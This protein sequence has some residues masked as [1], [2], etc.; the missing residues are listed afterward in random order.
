MI[1]RRKAAAGPFFGGQTFFAT[2]AKGVEEVLA[3]E[4]IGLGL[5]GVTVE[6]GG[7][8]FTGDLGACYRANLWL[9]TA[10][11]ILVPLAE[12]PCDSPQ[13]LYDGVR[14]LPWDRY[15]TP[16]TT[17][18]V[19]CV[20]RDSAL[21]HSGFVALKT[22]DAIVDTLRDRFGRRP[23][24]NPKD[25]D[26]LVNV[27]L[28]RNRCT[29]S[30]DSSG[31]GLDRRGYRTEAGEA[32]LRE[33]LAAALVFLTGWDGTVPL[34]DPLC[35]SGTIL[36]EAALMAMNRAPGLVRE[37]FGFQRW[38][39]FDAPRWRRLLDEARQ[40]ERTT[41]AAPL[42]GYDRLE[43]VLV[44]ARNNSRR[45]GVER[46]I[47]FTEGD[48]RDLVPPP[49]P[50]VLL[51]NPPYGKRLGDEEQLKPFYGQI[52]DVFKQRC[53]GYTAWLFTGGLDLAKSVGL[54][55]SRR[56]V[57]YNGPLECRLLRYDLY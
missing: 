2:T 39:T 29:V 53:A 7:V 11:R 28:A 40:A 43:D 44:V 16:D 46:F 18:A 31:F 1:I 56:I 26:L 3:R 25:P 21:T 37:R 8:R 30:L 9:R 6:K 55:A 14:A 15:L 17:L 27:H 23:N 41:L 20:L 35:G 22:K 33:T 4:M 52:G 38:P 47:S 48:V 32:P 49:A 5:E 57:L 34:V 50:G 24:V 12:F 13:G 51:T 45:A 10:S 54:K 36:I 19:E 42:V